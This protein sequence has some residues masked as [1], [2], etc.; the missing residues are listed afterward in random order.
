MPIIWWYL[1]SPSII[2]RWRSVLITRF[3]IYKITK[4][5][6]NMSE[7]YTPSKIVTT[8]SKSSL[9]WKLDNI[10]SPIIVLAYEWSPLFGFLSTL[11]YRRGETGTCYLPAFF[12]CLLRPNYLGLPL[13]ST[14]TS[15]HSIHVFQLNTFISF[16]LEIIWISYLDIDWW[17]IITNVGLKRKLR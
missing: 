11:S 3:L 10:T 7:Y 8:H 13:W 2:F 12:Y 9:K 6:P 14:T 16:Y 4:K 15:Q 1:D 17:H 5:I